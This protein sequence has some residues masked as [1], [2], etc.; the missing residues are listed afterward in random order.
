MS[1]GG[2]GMSACTKSLWAAGVTCGALAMNEVYKYLWAD[3][4]TYDG[5]MW[6]AWWSGFA[7]PC[8]GGLVAVAINCGLD[9][10]YK[11]M[12]SP[13]APQARQDLEMQFL[14]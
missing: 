11:R 1:A 5:G 7:G 14:N 8:K 13:P 3:E 10:V 4:S 2:P 12:T 9:S 6:D